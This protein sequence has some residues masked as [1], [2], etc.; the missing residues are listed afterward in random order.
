MLINGPVVTEFKC[1]DNFGMY[2]EGI[3]VQNDK[4][5]PEST[6][7][8]HVPSEGEVSFIQTQAKEPEEGSQSIMQTKSSS[9]AKMATQE[10][11]HTIFLV[12]WNKDE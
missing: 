4:P 6:E 3:L 7:T 8:M 1:D 5:I 10:L 12:G 9:K 11:N 2:K